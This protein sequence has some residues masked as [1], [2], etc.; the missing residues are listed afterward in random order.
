M[1]LGHNEGVPSTQ[2]GGRIIADLMA[3]EINEFTSH[4]IVNKKIPYAGPKVLRSFFG[5]LKK[6]VLGQC[7]KEHRAFLGS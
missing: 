4:F 1:A 7:C 3:G 2:T 6:N 5:A